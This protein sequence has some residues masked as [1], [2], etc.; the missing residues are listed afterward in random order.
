MLAINLPKKVEFMKKSAALVLSA[1]FALGLSL[2]VTADVGVTDKC[3]EEVKELEDKIDKN[4]DDYTSEARRKAK[5]NLAAARTNR[6]NP[7]KCRENLRDARQD[8]RDGKK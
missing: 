2:S 7:A 8:L 3:Q 6:A 5:A 4:K 1:L